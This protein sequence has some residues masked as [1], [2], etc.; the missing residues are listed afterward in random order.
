MKITEDVRQYA[1]EKGYGID[2]VL[3]R[4]LADKAQE[5]RKTAT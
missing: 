2:E 3:D 1:R 4:G 5:F